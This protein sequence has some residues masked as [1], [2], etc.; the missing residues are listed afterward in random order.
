MVA[1]RT[2]AARRRGTLAC[3]LALLA[4]AFALPAGACSTPVY[5]WALEKWRPDD[6]A[7]ALSLPESPTPDAT[8][9][10][11]ALEEHADTAAVNA[12]VRTRRDAEG[13][14]RLRVDFPDIS[15]IPV[16]AWD[17]PLTETSAARLLDSPARRELVERLASGQA[18]VW[19]LLQPEGRRDPAAADLLARMCAEVGP[20]VE[21]ARERSVPTLEGAE[22]E[23]AEDPVFSVIEVDRAA[24]EEAF[25]VESLLHTEPGLADLDAPLAFPVFGRGRALYA[26]AGAGINEHT[27]EEAHVFLVG[28]CQCT[29]KADNPGTDLLLAADWEALLSERLGQTIPDFLAPPV[30]PASAPAEKP[31][32]AGLAAILALAAVGAGSL[33]AAAGYVAWRRLRAP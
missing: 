21:K 1:P 7:L 28:A 14:A 11:T 15:G 2:E 9:A 27:V 32:P 8:A 18:G 23:L 16:P 3:A 33:L 20:V 30:D 24:P 13:P 6:Y 31:E 12:R 10:A 26:L 29:V 22:L 25:L 17:V 19:L 4:W 5:Q